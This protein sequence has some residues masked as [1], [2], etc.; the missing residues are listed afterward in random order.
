MG[1]GRK[2]GNSDNLTIVQVIDFG[3]ITSNRRPVVEK[4]FAL[5]Q[6]CGEYQIEADHCRFCPPPLIFAAPR[7]MVQ[8]RFSLG[9]KA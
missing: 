2:E 5:K 1:E 8:S 9:L 4:K 3:K 7:G 6:R